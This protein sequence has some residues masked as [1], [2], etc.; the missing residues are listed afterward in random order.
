[1]TSAPRSPTITA[2]AL[3]NLLAPLRAAPDDVMDAVFRDPDGRYVVVDWKTGRLPDDGRAPALAVQLAA[4]RLA[5][6]AL[7]IFSVI[8][9]LIVNSLGVVR[10]WFNK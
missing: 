6:A 7:T 9:G 2:A 8:V 5:W 3:V 4:Y 1:M 10:D